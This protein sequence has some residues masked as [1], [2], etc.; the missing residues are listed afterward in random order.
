MQFI[1]AAFQCT[2]SLVSPRDAIAR[3]IGLDV[4]SQRFGASAFLAARFRPV[5]REE[6]RKALIQF[7]ADINVDDPASVDALSNGRVLPQQLAEFWDKRQ[8]FA[9][10]A[11]RDS[12]AEGAAAFMAAEALQFLLGVDHIVSERPGDISLIKTAMINGAKGLFEVGRTQF[13]ALAQLSVNLTE[14]LIKDGAKK[15]AFIESPFGN[16]VPAAVLQRVAKARG[17][18]IDVIE[19]GCP[20]NDRSLRGRTVNDAARDISLD[21]IV[22]AAELVLF[23]DD[24]ITGSRFLKMA[25]ALRK[26]IGI[27]KV[28]TVAMRVRYTPSAGFPTGTKRDLSVVERWA[29]ERGMPFGEVN[30]P[31]LPIFRIDQLAPALMGSALIWSEAS[32]TSGKLKNNLIFVFIDKFEAIHAQLSARGESEARDMLMGQLWNLDTNGRRFGT[33][34]EIAA[35][36]FRQVAEKLPPDFFVGLRSSAMEAFPGDYY[37]RRISGADA[38]RARSDWLAQCVFQESRKFVSDREASWLNFAIQSLSNAGFTAD[39][40]AAPRDHSYGLYTVPLPPGLY[41][42]H[43]TLVDLVVSETDRKS[44]Q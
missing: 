34:P 19:W 26:A 21:P 24:A 16:S 5:A 13:S 39:I 38:I 41:L 30:L 23:V 36:A 12:L 25:K 9:P 15:I 20:R 18:H 22:K 42:L 17:L 35:R 2:T 29:T 31:D 44:H 27:H 3:H 37:G 14:W 4:H 33:S 1:H 6:L 8:Y 43:Q 32:L 10:H 7:C 28:A 11:D 40:D